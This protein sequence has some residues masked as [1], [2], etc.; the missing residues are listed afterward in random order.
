LLT[1]HFIDKSNE[2]DEELLFHPLSS[3]HLDS[4]EEL[5]SRVGQCDLLPPPS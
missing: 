3:S 1:L 2:V 4:N 5:D